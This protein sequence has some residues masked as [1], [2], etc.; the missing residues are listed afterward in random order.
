MPHV[1]RQVRAITLVACAAAIAAVVG[2]GGCSKGSSAIPNPRASVSPT[3]SPSGSPTPTP[4]PTPTA[5]VFVSMA[6][7]SMQPTTDPVYGV[8]DGYALISPP[9]SPTPSPSGS[10]SPTPVPSPTPTRT[11]GPSGIINVPCN[12]NIEFMNFD[13]TSFHT[14]S[15]LSPDGGGPFPA[16]FNNPL[17]IQSSPVL[18][19]ISYPGA[20][21]FLFSSGAVLN[22]TKGVP[23]V[24]AVFSTGNQSGAYYIGDFYDYDN[25]PSMRTVI[26]V[27]G[28]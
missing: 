27:S 21:Q 2:T 10:P 9:P 28:C 11:P 15:T 25:L 13:S 19:P 1:S 16:H 23:G 18:T 4:S 8:V 3:P 7:A 12:T 6:Y 26:V 22:S 20:P 17:G 24:S 5:N 14:A